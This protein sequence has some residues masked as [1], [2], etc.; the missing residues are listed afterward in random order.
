MPVQVLLLVTQ[1]R[2]SASSVSASMHD[3][4]L[5]A[6]VYTAHIHEQHTQCATHYSLILFSNSYFMSVELLKRT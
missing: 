6:A 3:Q 2:S 5:F 4:Q 1:Q